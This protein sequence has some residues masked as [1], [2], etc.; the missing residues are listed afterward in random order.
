MK[1]IAYL[2]VPILSIHVRGMNFICMLQCIV[3]IIDRL[4]TLLNVLDLCV[5]CFEYKV[6]MSHIN[7]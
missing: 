4:N 1:V 6:G 3:N 2:V 5:A 7:Q